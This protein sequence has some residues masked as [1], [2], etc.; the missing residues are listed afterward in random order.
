MRVQVPL[1]AP[2]FKAML[3][4][5]ITMRKTSIILNSVGLA[6]SSFCFLHCVLVVLVFAGL[7]APSLIVINFFDD[8][9]NHAILIFSGLTF[10]G[11][12]LIR[13]DI[14]YSGEVNLWYEKFKIEFKG[15]YNK[16][17]LAGAALL[18][19]SFIVNGI[20]SEMSVIVGALLLLS[21]HARKLAKV[22]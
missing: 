14:T 8:P 6:V 12:S 18:S 4:Y 16:N 13:L 1:S 5:N 11:L 17:F 9:R 19:L 15:L 22:K 10:A 3:R 20:Y 7:I 21:M 2:S